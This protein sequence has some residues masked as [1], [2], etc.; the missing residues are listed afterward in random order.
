MGRDEYNHRRVGLIMQD[1]RMFR[2]IVGVRQSITNNMD[3]PSMVLLCHFTDG[4]GGY[5]TADSDCN[6]FS[7]ARESQLQNSI[8]STVMVH[9]GM[10]H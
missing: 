3:K 7:V 4:R 9:G 10:R 1:H 2:S 5:P 6:S 8:A